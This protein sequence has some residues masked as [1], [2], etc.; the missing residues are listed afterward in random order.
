[1]I[2]LQ[3]KFKIYHHERGYFDYFMINVDRTNTGIMRSIM[4]V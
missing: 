1:V 3:H 2:V 4:G